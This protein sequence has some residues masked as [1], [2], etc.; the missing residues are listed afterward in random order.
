MTRNPTTREIISIA[1][2]A[3]GLCGFVCL[4]DVRLE[5][6]DQHD[7]RGFLG[8]S[9]DMK[10]TIT[11]STYQQIVIVA[12]A[13]IF[14]SFHR[15]VSR[16]ADQIFTARKPSGACV[17][18]WKKK[19]SR[20]FDKWG[21]KYLSRFNVMAIEHHLK[22]AKRSGK[23]ETWTTSGILMRCVVY[24]LAGY[25]IFVQNLRRF[26]DDAGNYG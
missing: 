1:D 21:D 11:E 5:S 6:D 17:N 8:D 15:L 9:G 22:W 23:F 19:M 25:L 7:Q 18:C 24:G 14:F 4:D 2:H 3:A 26:H 10:F 20:I 12:A 13:A 16:L